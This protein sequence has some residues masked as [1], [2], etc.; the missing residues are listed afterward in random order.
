MVQALEIHALPVS[1]GAALNTLRSAFGVHVIESDPKGNARPLDDAELSVLYETMQGM[2]AAWY[3][4]F[5][6]KPINFWIDKNPGGGGYSDSWIR[7][8]DPM[9]DPSVL[10]RILIHEGTHASNEYRGWMY[11]LEWCTRPGL[12]WRKVGDQWTHPR[13]QGGQH[14]PGEWESLPTDTRDVS[15]APGEDLAEMVRYYVHSVRGERAYLWPLDLSKPAVYLW[16]TS[17]TRH[18]FVRDIFLKLPPEHRWYKPLHPLL[19]LHARRN[20]GI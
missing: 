13:I 7:I 8:G 11:E 10:Y 18:V 14:Q 16:D 20:L 9:G 19:E 6:A 5:R 1:R 4:D 3:G 17:P 15:I 12:D 2:G